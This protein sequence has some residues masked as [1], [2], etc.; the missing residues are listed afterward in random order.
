MFCLV[1]LF[2]SSKDRKWWI[3]LFKITILDLNYSNIFFQFVVTQYNCAIVHVCQC[4]H[5]IGQNRFFLLQME[6]KIWCSR[7]KIF[8]AAKLGLWSS[9]R[10]M[11]PLDLLPACQAPTLFRVF[12]PTHTGP[13]IGRPGPLLP[14]LHPHWFP[15]SCST[16]CKNM[17]HAFL[18]TLTLD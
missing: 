18:S 9:L 14:S 4:Y 13:R 12:M 7:D 3:N 17:L 6:H 15:I 2:S 8:H 16:Y 5:N 1:T 11:S 10:S